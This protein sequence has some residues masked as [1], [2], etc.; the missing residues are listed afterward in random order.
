MTDKDSEIARLREKLQQSR[1]ENKSLKSKLNTAKAKAAKAR[2][3][4]KSLKK[5]RCVPPP[6]P[7]EIVE[8]F[9]NMLDDTTSVNP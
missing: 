4:V 3:E 5:K 9:L 6:I 2:E 7:E 1:K 8:E